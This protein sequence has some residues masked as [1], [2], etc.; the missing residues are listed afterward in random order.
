MVNGI[1]SDTALVFVYGGV[2]TL[3]LLLIAGAIISLLRSFTPGRQDRP[4]GASHPLFSRA[5]TYSLG[6]AAAVFGGVGLLVLLLL[7]IDPVVGTLVALGA[8]LLAG[9]I[10]LGLL[11]YLPSRGR[12]E[13]KLIDF[14]ATGRRATVVIPIPGNGIGEVTF[15][16]GRKA[17]NLAARS[18]TGQPIDKETIVVIERVTKRV[19]VVSPLGEGSHVVTTRPS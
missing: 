19:A 5:A 13:E 18:T 7:P 12:V 10:A 3:G 14:D 1:F 8:G 9:L 15:R 4:Q 2:L 16:D 17:I 11:V 6:L